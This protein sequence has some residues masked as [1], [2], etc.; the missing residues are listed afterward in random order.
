M[1]SKLIVPVIYGQVH[2]GCT[3]Q[4]RAQAQD[5]EASIVIIF[6]QPPEACS[7]DRLGNT[8]CYAEMT[9][10]LKKSFK[11]KEF[12][13]IENLCLVGFEDLKLYLKKFKSL[14]GSTLKFKINKLH[15]PVDVITAGCQF[16]LSSQ[17]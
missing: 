8:P 11:K 15:P 7:T 17:L 4:E 12:H 3:A 10:V 1:R 6:S 16:V 14:E 13:T 9:E 5:I 2:L